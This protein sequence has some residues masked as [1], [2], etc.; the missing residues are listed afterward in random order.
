L[1]TLFIVSTNIRRRHL[2]ESQRAMIASELAK[3]GLGANQHQEG[4]SIDAP[5]V[6][7]NQAADMMQVS[8][9]YV[10]RAR[11]VQENAPDLLGE[12]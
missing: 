10:Q 6:K 5:S 2:T 8:R 9:A 12:Y 11:Q 3:L 7:Q 1:R 4:A